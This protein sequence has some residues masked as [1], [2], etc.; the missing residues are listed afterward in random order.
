MSRKDQA[1]LTSL[2]SWAKDVLETLPPLLSRTVAA[3]TL[4]VSTRTIDRRIRAGV[5]EAVRTGRRVLIPRV[6][7]VEHL[8]S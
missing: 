1:P 6:C 4:G 2:A 8:A 5:L 7:L 3:K